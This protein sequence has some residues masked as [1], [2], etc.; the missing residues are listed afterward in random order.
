MTVGMDIHTDSQL[1]T[2]PDPQ[3]GLHR[4]LTPQGQ[5]PQAPPSYTARI[6]LT[7]D[8]IAVDG[9]AVRPTPGMTV[10]V[11][12]RTGE[13]RLIEFVLQPVLRYAEEGLRER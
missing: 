13:R 5:N 7:S 1:S 2:K 8:T 4:V 9:R 3:G 11:V 6:A 12:V 10:T